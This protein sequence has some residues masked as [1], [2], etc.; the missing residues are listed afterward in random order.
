M[1]NSK[2]E[3]SLKVFN[4][5]ILILA[6]IFLLGGI[7]LSILLKL[8]IEGDA[9]SNIVARTNLLNAQFERMIEAD[10]QT[11]NTLKSFWR[12]DQQSSKKE[13]LIGLNE[14][15]EA[16]KFIRMSIMYQ[17]DT[18]YHVTLNEGVKKEEISQLDKNLQNSINESWNGKNAVSKIYYDSDLMRSVLVVSVPIKKG[19]DVFAVLAA[20]NDVAIYEDLF[21]E[22]MEDNVYVHVISRDGTFLIR[23]NHRMIEGESQS[24]YSMK[25]SYLEEG[26]VRSA[27]EKKE[28]YYDAF[29]YAGRKYCVY[30]KPMS[31]DDCYIVVNAPFHSFQSTWVDNL[32]ISTLF[33][34]VI[35]LLFGICIIQTLRLFKR[36]TFLLKKIAYYDELTGL[37]NIHKFKWILANEMKQ[38]ASYSIAILNVKNFQFIN[39]TFG[40]EYGDRVLRDM[41]MLINQMR[42]DG[43]YCCRETSDQFVL[44][45]QGCDK[46]S[47]VSRIEGLKDTVVRYFS[48]SGSNYAMQFS[49]GIC[50]EMDEPNKML[51]NA[52][53][54]M[55]KAKQ[56]NESYVFFDNTLLNSIQ[57]QN[58]IESSM[59]RALSKKEFKVFL[60]PKYDI[61]RMEIVGAEAL[62]RWFRE[63][64]TMFY[65]DQFIPL[66]ERNGFCIELDL[67]ILEQVCIKLKE[68]ME[69]GMKV[70][71]ISVNQTK[72]LFYRKDYVN[73][74]CKIVSRYGISPNLIVL[75]ILEGLAVEDL[76]TFR[77]CL[78]ELH[79][80]GFRVSLDDF[81]SGYSSLSNLYEL[82]VDEI[83][84]DKKF[85]DLLGG[86]N[87]VANNT[88]FKKIISLVGTLESEVI[89]EGV[90]TQSHVE[91]LRS[92]NCKYAQGYYFSRPISLEDYEKM[93]IAG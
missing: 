46:E 2:R 57:L 87:D 22:G 84:I 63:D 88:I 26:K 34:G 16:N 54:A 35:G 23:S 79:E 83:K 76:D 59:Y 6:I 56:L 58:E 24:I 28:E 53:W 9:K 18:I 4:L 80:K 92:M 68:W 13:I 17:D 65:P 10:F 85:L 39:D 64:G 29:M 43:E 71:P 14:S 42:R 20:Y 70:H 30:F 72:L 73:T 77:H 75:E 90:E 21:K 38:K 66:F 19:N 36:N 52:H 48:N 82:H 32:N 11:L 12:F 67:Y 51:S 25:E 62:V 91:F 37:Y 7:I 44:L 74:V 60:Q 86:K 31:L 3:S 55:K 45:L 41:A 1:Y 5:L 49:I 8:A 89:V 69:K 27:L 50:T 33:Y 40:V 15:N 93:M 78:D 81:G 47:I 61:D